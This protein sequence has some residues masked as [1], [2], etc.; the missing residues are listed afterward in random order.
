MTPRET[1]EA[2]VERINAQDPDGLAE[3]LA[4]P[5]IVAVGEAGLDFHY[6]HS[7]R[8][9]QREAFR[10]QIRLARDVGLPIV[11]HTREADEETARW[12]AARR[13]DADV[14]A[15]TARFRQADIWIDGAFALEQGF[16]FSA[17][18]LSAL[19]V[20]VIER[21][22]FRAALQQQRVH[23][24]APAQRQQGRAGR[25][26]RRPARR[27]CGARCRRCC[28]SRPRR[29]ARSARPSS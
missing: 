23:G 27:R 15:L 6:D 8:P 13:P 19:T 28:R 24:A 10:R 1:F 12:I 16:I 17:M 11:V 21:Q 18:I 3:L 7:P 9:A 26:P 2:F 22:F 20:A 4:R 29:A 5:E 14:E 25:S